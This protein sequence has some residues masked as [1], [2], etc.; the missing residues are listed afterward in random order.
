METSYTIVKLKALQ[1]AAPCENGCPHSRYQKAV[2]FYYT[3][4]SVGG[5]S[6]GPSLWNVFS[7]LGD[8]SFKCLNVTACRLIELRVLHS[9]RIC[10]KSSS[11]KN[12]VSLAGR[13]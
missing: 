2:I 1:E 7:S 8:W 13:S 11:H 10:S 4:E 6:N 3:A 12:I 5:K 9:Y